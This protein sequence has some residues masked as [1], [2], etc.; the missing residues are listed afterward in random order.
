MTQLA[1]VYRGKPRRKKSEERDTINVSDGLYAT[2]RFLFSIRLMVVAISITHHTTQSNTFGS[3]IPYSDLG[4][5]KEEYATFSWRIRV[6]MI[7]IGKA[8]KP[9]RRRLLVQKLQVGYQVSERRACCVVGHSSSTEHYQSTRNDRAALR[10]R[11][12]D[13]A[14]TRVR[15]GYLRIHV[16]LRREGWLVNKKLVYRIYCEKGLQFRSKTRRRHKSCQV[17]QDQPKATS[18]NESWSMDFMADQLFTTQRF[19]VL[20]PSLPKNATIT[21]V[22]RAWPSVQ[23]N[24]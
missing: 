18:A 24:V 21:F 3:A 8:L 2:S 23:V 1:S 14:A 20:T 4:H 6:R 19:R 15:Y 16:L 11:L 22:S 12:R 9:D 10:L 17:R 13:L 5:S 7:P